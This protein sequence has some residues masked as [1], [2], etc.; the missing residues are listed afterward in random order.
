VVATR[1][2]P[3]LPLARLRAQNQMTEVRAGQLRF[4]RQEAAAFLTGLMALDLPQDE[5]ATLAARTEGWVAGLQ[6]AALSLRNQPDRSAFVHAFSGTD[7]YIMDYLVDEVLSRQPAGVQRFLI[8]TSI[9]ERLSGPLCQAVVDRIDPAAE[10]GAQAL[11]EYLEQANLFVT[12]L[13]NQR[14]WYRY[15]HLFAELLRARLRQLYPEQVPSLYLR[16]ASWCEQHGFIHEAITYALAGHEWERAATWLE[17]HALHFL[18]R[19]EMAT[20]VH[21]IALLPEETA[22][23]RPRLSLELAWLLTYAN[24]L[25]EVEP[26][27][28]GV[29]SATADADQERP[30]ASLAAEGQVMRAS[31]LLV[32][33]YLALATANPCRALALA[34]EVGQLLGAGD[35]VA[36]GHLRESIYLHWVC[37]YAHRM[38]GDLLQA[39]DYLAQAVSLSR[40]SGEPWHCMVAM[41]DLSVVYRRQGRLNEATALLRQILQLAGNSTVP[42]HGYLSRVEGHLALILLEQNKLP[43]ALQHARRAVKRVQ[44][45][46]SHNHVAAAYAILAQVQMAQDDRQAAALSLQGA[47]RARQEANVLPV[48][49]SLVES[50]QVRLWLSQGDIAAA[51]KWADGFRHLSRS[52]PAIDE[53]MESKYITLARFLIRRGRQ[54]G[55]ATS[56]DEALAL[57]TRLQQAAQAG[58]RGHAVIE[59]GVLHSLAMATRAAVQSQTAVADSIMLEPL[60]RLLPLARAGGYVRVFLDEG[61]LLA[62]LLHRAAGCGIERDY[63]RQL[64]A[65]FA[66]EAAEPQVESARPSGAMDA[67]DALMIEPLSDRELEVLQLIAG[68]LSNG[69]IAQKLYLSL[70]TVKGHTRNIYGKLHVHSRTQAVAR[71]T[72]MG[73]LPTP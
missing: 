59:A 60:R 28:R 23:R 21:W 7:R 54:N 3:P 27:L 22:R 26:L 53:R 44:T 39:A 5:V 57:L 73:L 47:D 10:G 66:M 56:I 4:G 69:E 46:Q 11:L 24:R 67:D 70:N 62:E 55:D 58:G 12:S 42:N 71:A 2:D 72:A 6:L 65:A 38:S 25:D 51:E 1:A 48:V 14:V 16:A 9:L 43:E 18:T 49:D 63:C 15:H 68:G 31:A 40:I 32:R 41:T 45:W 50:G 20:L 30:G 37:G 34:Q 13:D 64:L 19:G 52:E 33:A 8:Q 61:P 29:E 35:P 17:Q 36:A